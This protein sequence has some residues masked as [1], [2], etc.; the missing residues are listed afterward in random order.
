MDIIE[1][2]LMKKDDKIEQ[3]IKKI[4]ESKNYKNIYPPTVERIVLDTFARYPQSRVE[5]ESKR[6]LHQISKVY[7]QLKSSAE[8]NLR[9]H[10]STKE[11]ENF[12]NE[13]YRYIFSIVGNV[14]TIIDVA[15]GMN[16]LTYPYM[17]TE[18][19]YVGFDIDQEVIDQ[20]KTEI[21]ST[22]YSTKINVFPGDVY[23]I[24]ELSSDVCFLFKVVP[25][26]EQQKKGSAEEILQKIKS[27]YIVVTFPTKSLSNNEKGMELF[28]TEFMDKLIQRLGYQY[29][30][31]AFENELV[32]IVKKPN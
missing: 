11:R 14:E 30:K 1:Y 25:L 19:R 16:P 7:N 28:Y 9:K 24:D 31:M 2:P 4:L 32:F 21:Q 20:V 3:I 5:N 15:C 10:S 29:D 26:L 17:K 23:D 22:D 13:F 18:A 12:L 6:R 27:R 8:N